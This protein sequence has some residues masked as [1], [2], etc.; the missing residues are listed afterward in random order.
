MINFR[1]KRAQIT[2]FVILGILLV[3]GLVLFLSLRKTDSSVDFTGQADLNA[4]L[5]NINSYSTNCFDN[6]VDKSVKDVLLQGGYYD[7]SEVNHEL[8]GSFSIPYYFKDYTKIVPSEERVLESIRLMIIDNFDSCVDDYSA[9]DDFDIE[10][11][12]QSTSA[13]IE[14]DNG[15]LIS[16]NPNLVVVKNDLSIDVEGLTKFVVLDVNSLLLAAEEII[17][18]HIGF[19]QGYVSLTRI[20]AAVNNH[21]LFFNALSYEDSV[22]LLL[23]NSVDSSNVLVFMFELNN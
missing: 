7:L 2:I 21:G 13:N 6:V 11:V 23:K 16:L 14:S 10:I 3:V 8:I 15:L 12:K 4:V 20:S 9:F 17:D 18:S 5:A 1:G 22:V 19:D